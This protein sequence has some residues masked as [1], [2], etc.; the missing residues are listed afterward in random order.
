MKRRI[1][2]IRLTDGKSLFY[3]SDEEWNRLYD[4][5]ET[6][7]IE[8]SYTIAGWNEKFVVVQNETQKATP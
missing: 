8:E 6:V 4:Q 7:E 1:K 3:P 2:Q 5:I